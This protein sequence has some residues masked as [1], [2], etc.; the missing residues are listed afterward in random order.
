MKF[1][2]APKL[3]LYPRFHATVKSDLDGVNLS[4]E[5]IYVGMTPKMKVIQLGIM[6]IME[7][8]LGEL[9]RANQ[10]LDV[11]E[12]NMETVVTEA[13]DQQIRRQLDPIWHRVTL[14]S[15]QLVAE[16]R[17][18]R[19]LLG[20]LV[21]YDPISYCKFM[22][23]LI[24]ADAASGLGVSGF[25]SYWM[26]MDAA[27]SIIKTAQDR[28]YSVSKQD[29]SLKPCIEPVPK[30]RALEAVLRDSKDKR[31]VIVTQEEHTRRQLLR[32]IALGYDAWQQAKFEE[33]TAWRRRARKQGGFATGVSVG[34]ASVGPRRK[35]RPP[36]VPV[37]E[38]IGDDDD[39]QASSENPATAWEEAV[40]IDEL[41]LPAGMSIHCYADKENYARF[42]EC[43][44]T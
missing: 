13:F 37:I 43:Q 36:K 1:L 22:E 10:S 5:E 2:K 3:F 14:K 42:L 9:M 16:L 32:I 19:L 28:V 18:L 11:R 4:V 17:V 26:M 25:K 23:T 29:G 8:C 6:E 34:D 38:K 30:W 15:K 21:Q 31:I 24:L 7:S 35:S 20:Y 27:H 33:F 44:S 40:N 39:D 41:E 12:C